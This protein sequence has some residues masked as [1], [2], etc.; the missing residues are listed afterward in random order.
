MLLRE[1]DLVEAESQE[2]LAVRD[3]RAAVAALDRAQGTI[4]ADRGVEVEAAM[5]L[6]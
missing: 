3:Y 4:L 2:I 6:R 5:P 1:E